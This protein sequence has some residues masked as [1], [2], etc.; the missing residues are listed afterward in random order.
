MTLEVLG[1]IPSAVEEP[2]GAFHMCDKKCRMKG[3]KFYE[4]AAIVT[5]EE[6]TTHMI[7]LCRIC[8]DKKAVGA[9]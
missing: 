5:E 3:F 8:F 7:N 2:R 1:F 6:G 4:L 9:K